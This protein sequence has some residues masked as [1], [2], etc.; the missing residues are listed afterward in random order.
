MGHQQS[1]LP[2]KESSTAN[3]PIEDVASNVDVYGRKWIV[4]QVNVGVLVDG[5]CQRQ[6]L[7]LASGQVDPF[8]ADLG[9]RSG[10]Q[11]FEVRTKAAAFDNGV[12]KI[13]R[14]RPLEKDVVFYSCILDP[15]LGKKLRNNYNIY[16]ITA[17]LHPSRSLL[18]LNCLI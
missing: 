7:L 13:F 17:I 14:K 6:P 2:V 10:R 12:E 16:Y 11:G 5:S 1:G 9:V 8:F 4:Q 15:C 3:D 18:N